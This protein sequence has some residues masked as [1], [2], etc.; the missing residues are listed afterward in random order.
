MASIK[1]V[2][3]EAG[4]STATVS[5]VLAGKPHVRTALQKRVLAAVEK[6]NYRPNLVARSLRAQQSSTIGLIV[7]DIR[8]PYF[9]AVSRAVEDTA[10]ENGF[11]VFLCNT[12]E[13]PEK[14]L[15]YLNLM[16]DEN[17]AGLIFSPTRQTAVRFPQL[18]LGIPT[19]VV[20]RSVK[21]DNVDVV[22]IDNVAAARQLAVHLLENGYRR[23]AAL[24]GEASTTGRQRRQGFEE[25]LVAYGLP[26]DKSLLQFVAPKIDAGKTAALALLDLADPPDAFFTTNSLLTAGALLAVRERGLTIPDDVGLVGFDET[27]WS[28]L[29]QPAITLIAQPTE[30]I[31][32]TATELLLKRIDDPDRTGREVILTARLLVRG[33]SASRIV[34]PVR[35]N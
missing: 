16:R 10:H 30:E 24:F 7:S 4:V 20:D 31:G 22:L 28:T 15:M 12:D 32:R 5:R 34:E 18:N 1:D 27:T 6:L 17:V 35:S 14:E 26:V 33:S 13:N 25:A 9:T 2:A 8:N 29:V 23:I 21:A 11:S 3:E 19:V